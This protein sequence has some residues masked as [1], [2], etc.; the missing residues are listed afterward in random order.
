MTKAAVFIGIDISKARLD[1]AL[2]PT[3][4]PDPGCQ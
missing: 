1:V 2:R 4:I 3:G